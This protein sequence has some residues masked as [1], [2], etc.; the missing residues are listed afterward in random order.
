[1]IDDV[2]RLESQAS[3]A[4]VS[5]LAV[6]IPFD[7]ER[8]VVPSIPSTKYPVVLAASFDGSSDAAVAALR[9]AL[10]AGHTVEIDAQGAGEEGWERLEDLLTKATFAVSTG[11]IILCE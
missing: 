6:S 10:T 8:G 4:G 5:V 7:L 11:L 3:E 9:S 1:M 2:I